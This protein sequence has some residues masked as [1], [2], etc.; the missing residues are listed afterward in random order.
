MNMVKCI[1]NKLYQF[2]MK[3]HIVTDNYTNLLE[4]D[5]GPVGER[6][7][8]SELQL[9]IVK[10]NISKAPYAAYIL[11]LYYLNFRVSEFLELTASD[12]YISNDNIKVFVGER[13]QRMVQIASFQFIRILRR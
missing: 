5:R 3:D 12:Y 10:K 4:L 1:L 9:Q 13:K 11:A 8:F 6:T 7:R 2:A